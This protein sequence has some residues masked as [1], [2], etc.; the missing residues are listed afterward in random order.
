MSEGP[1]TSESIRRTD[2]ESS[3]EEPAL[4]RDRKPRR[5]ADRPRVRAI[6]EA[7]PKKKEQLRL[8]IGAE[9]SLRIRRSN[10][11]RTSIERILKNVIIEAKSQ[12]LGGPEGDAYD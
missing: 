2:A 12:V 6:P 7:E 8:F 5:E 1:S 4:S 3:R 10:R 9:Y 11:S